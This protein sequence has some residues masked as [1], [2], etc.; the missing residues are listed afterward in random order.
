MAGAAGNGLIL[1]PHA[2]GAESCCLLCL[3]GGALCCE[4]LTC[5]RCRVCPDGPF[6]DETRVG[7]RGCV[8]DVGRVGGIRVER[9]DRCRELIGR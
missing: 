3:D 4:E 2:P 5:G 8:G 9:A 1:P 7:K 6:R